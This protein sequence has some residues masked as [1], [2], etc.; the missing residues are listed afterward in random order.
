MRD[1]LDD[2]PIKL[3]RDRDGAR[4]SLRPFLLAVLLCVLALGLILLDRSGTLA[5]VRG[6][7]QQALSPLA[8]SL[9]GARGWAADLL[10]GPH[11]EQALHERL[12][13]LEQENGQLRAE[14][15]RTEQIRA[16]NEQLRTQ[17]TIA[18]QYP[19]RM[20]GAEVVSR[21]P[22]AGRRIVT[23][24]RG[25]RDGIAVGMAVVGQAADHPAALIGIVET[26]GPRTA[27]VLLI[28]DF[29][30]QISARVLHQGVARLGLVQGQWQRGSRLRLEELERDIELAP[31]DPVF[32]AGLTNLLDLPLALSYVPA[33][34]PIGSI[35]TVMIEGQRRVAELRPFVDPDQVRYVWVILN[36]DE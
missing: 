7:L 22:D 19:W 2:R 20:A 16:E 30:S 34:I 12:Q 6:L 29:A 35:E 13:L 27:D 5:P 28:T 9:S 10:A 17:L 8:G 26:V 14:L 18:R 4:A 32:S 23:I 1:Y 33:D 11:G 25:S 21:S 3:R 31:G 15:L 36:H 24:S